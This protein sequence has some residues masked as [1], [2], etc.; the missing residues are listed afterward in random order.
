MDFWR[1]RLNE[2]KEKYTLAAIHCKDAGQDLVDGALPTP[3]GGVNYRYAL[4]SES[5]ARREYLRILRI[6]TDLVVDSKRPGE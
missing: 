6:Y 3:D 4:R 1:G 2:A 5:T